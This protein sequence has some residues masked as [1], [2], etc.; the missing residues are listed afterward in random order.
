MEG[1]SSIG[2]AKGL[3]T[4]AEEYMEINDWEEEQVA[5]VMKL[6]NFLAA[7]ASG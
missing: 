5:A 3:I 6:L 4:M 7:R 2:L 1:D